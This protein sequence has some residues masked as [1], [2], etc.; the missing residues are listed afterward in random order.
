M[1][2]RKTLAR[3]ADFPPYR[4]ILSGPQAKGGLQLPAAVHGSILA[5]RLETGRAVIAYDPQRPDLRP[6]QL[7]LRT[8]LLSVGMGVDEDLPTA[9]DVLTRIREA[10]ESRRTSAGGSTDK[11]GEA[12]QRFRHWI[13]QAKAAGAIDMHLRVLAGGKGEVLMR[14]G[15]ELEPLPDTQAG[16]SD[17]DVLLAIKAAFENLAE[18]HS[19]S[20]PVYSES[21][22][23]SC[24]IEQRLGI[25]NLRLRFNSQRGL[26]GPKAAIR[27]LRYDPNA[28]PMA[29]K[30][31]GFEPSQIRIWEQAQRMEAGLILQ[32][33]ITGS[34]KTTTAK[35]FL[36]THPKNPAGQGGDHP[37]A[38]FYQVAD[39]IEYTLRGVHQIPVQRSISDLPDPGKKDEYSHVLDSLMRM[40]PDGIDVGEI[41]DPISAR[42]AMTVAKTGHLA[43][44]TCHTDSIAGIPNRLTDPRL[45]ISRDE[46]TAGNVIALL[47]YQALLPVLCPHCAMPATEAMIQLLSGEHHAEWRHVDRVV[48]TIQEHFRLPIEPLRFRNLEGC[49]HCMQR[50]QKGLT[51]VAEIMIPDEGWLDLT[52][53]GRDRAAWRHY[54][55]TYS[56]RDL[57]SEDMDGKT[58]LEHALLKAMRGT[59]DPRHTD[60]FARALERYEVLV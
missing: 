33:G 46:L 10:C 21:M 35:T 1:E 4:D 45:G 23:I 57:L 31:M 60:R 36:E 2:R 12:A 48:R 19:N 50:G 16:L 58:V 28:P 9:P 17:S 27:L 52:R 40:D 14:V 41:R 47:S 39:P 38:A 55:S 49:A 34:G 3:L 6:H 22:S 37:R 25:P 26:H 20:N 8:A 5:V 59:I 56:D 7:I 43:I 15:G 53:E 30:T 32:C 24:M 13:S 29:F 18:Q 44:A 51:I 42:A 11:L 54:R